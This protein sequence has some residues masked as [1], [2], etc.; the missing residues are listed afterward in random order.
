MLLQKIKLNK[1]L[2]L[3]AHIG[4]NTKSLNKT[5]NS[6]IIGNYQNTSIIN[7][8]YLLWSWERISQ[9]FNNLFL[10]KAKFFILGT[11]PN[12]PNLWLRSLLDSQLNLSKAQ[13]P[14]FLGYIG[15]NWSGGLL[16]NWNKLW[17]FVITS[18][19]KLSKNAKL[20][21]KQEKLLQKIIDRGNRGITPAFP[22]FLIAL[23]IDS[24]LIKEASS[25]RILT[26]GLVDSNKSL[27]SSDFNIISNDDSLGILEFLF[28]LLDKS[29]MSS[30]RREQDLF[31]I[32]V[33]KKLKKLLVNG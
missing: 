14:S 12:I 19:K 32:L 20:S 28:S 9:L 3:R 26:V 25:S 11:N 27:D 21:K 2:Y 22:D 4:H 1:F 16:S 18:F 17:L 13:L 5:M 8:D 33:F 29:S 31:Y 6:F 24:T 15:S 7:S 10:I 23:S 30:N